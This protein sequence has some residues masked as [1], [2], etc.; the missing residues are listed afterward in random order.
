[1]AYRNVI[2]GTDGSSTAE[3]AVQHAASLAADHEARLVI[4]TAYEP[5]RDVNEESD[6]VPADLRWMLTDRSQAEQKAR[7]G[8]E[9]AVGAGAPSIVVQAIEGSPADVLLEAAGDF[10]ADCIVVGSRGLTSAAHFVMGSVASSVSHHAP[11][12]VLIVHTTGQS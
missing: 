1:M 6:R 3:L 9:I 4:V 10:G 7:H 5:Q 12:D 8:K 2:V 11:C